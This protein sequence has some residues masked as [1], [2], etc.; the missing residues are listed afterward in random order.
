MHMHAGAGPPLPFQALK[1]RGAE[2]KELGRVLEESAGSRR[3][4]I[5][6]LLWRPANAILENLLA[7][8]PGQWWTGAAAPAASM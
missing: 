4:N 3:V 8:Q 2:G 1:Q 7:L 6:L 5:L